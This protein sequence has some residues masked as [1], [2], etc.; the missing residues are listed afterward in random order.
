[1]GLSLQSVT[2]ARNEGM[3]SK[4]DVLKFVIDDQAPW[5]THKQASALTVEE[6]SD[7]EFEL[8]LNLLI[9]YLFLGS[10]IVV[11]VAQRFGKRKSSHLLFAVEK[12]KGKAE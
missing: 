1:M 11:V 7:G 6:D 10:L 5:R 8:F 3:Y 2:S 9:I 4:R 12:C